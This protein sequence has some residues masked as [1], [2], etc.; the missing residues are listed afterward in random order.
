MNELK[1]SHQATNKTCQAI[2]LCPTRFASSRGSDI[3]RS[4]GQTTKNQFRWTVPPDEANPRE[5][6]PS[7]RA[8]G[9]VIGPRDFERNLRL[10]LS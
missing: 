1:V 5:D 6:G 7:V 2:F 3:F 8:V 4:V 10:T 9:P